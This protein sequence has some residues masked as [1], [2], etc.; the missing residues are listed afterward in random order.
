MVAKWRRSPASSSCAVNNGT[1][2]AG[3]GHRF[4]R[5]AEANLTGASS[6]QPLERA[7]GGAAANANLDED[8][9]QL[10]AYNAYLA[11]INA[12]GEGESGS[13]PK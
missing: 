7:A 11:R 3:I 9:D 8:E 2:G 6:A 12:H 4:D 1:L 13:A 5:F 10:T